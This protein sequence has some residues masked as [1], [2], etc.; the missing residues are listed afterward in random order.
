MAQV[1]CF[2]DGKLFI[3]EGTEP[4]EGALRLASGPTHALR[5]MV[6]KL[7]D[8][9]YVPGLE[10]STDLGEDQRLLVEFVE[11]LKSAKDPLA[12]VDNLDKIMLEAM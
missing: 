10:K 8:D 9:G 1:F 3:E 7:A 4:P 12:T 11:T 6:D 5:R 2:R